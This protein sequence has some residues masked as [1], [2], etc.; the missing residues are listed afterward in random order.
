MLTGLFFT[1]HSYEV[2]VVHLLGSISSCRAHARYDHANQPP[3]TLSDCMFDLT[4]AA[5]ANEP[6][7]HKAKWEVED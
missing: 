3:E 7:C 6:Y 2:H 1:P 5:R 4:N